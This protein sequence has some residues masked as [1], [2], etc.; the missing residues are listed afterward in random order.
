MRAIV[1]VTALALMAAGPALAASD[2][3]KDG[4]TSEWFK[5]LII[6]GS[7]GWSC[8][9]QSDCH[10]TPAEFTDGHWVAMTREGK[11]GEWL[12]VP[13]ESILKDK[14]SPFQK[15]GIGLAVLCEAKTGNARAVPVTGTMG[16]KVMVYC[17]T[18]PPNFG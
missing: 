10:P 5:S 6:P 16:S 9:D 7:D 1:L 17:F 3:Y 4:A 14:V 15:D 2:T 8:C 12:P 13:D 18:I 11:D